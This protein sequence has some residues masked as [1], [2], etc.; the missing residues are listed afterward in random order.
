MRQ[1]TERDL[2]IVDEEGLDEYL[3]LLSVSET[4]E[5]QGL[6]FLAFLRSVDKDVEVFARRRRINR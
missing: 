2:R 4:C 5:Y 6:D 3:T 1:S